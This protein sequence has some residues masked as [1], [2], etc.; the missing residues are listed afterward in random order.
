MSSQLSVTILVNHLRSLLEIE[1]AANGARVRAKR[2]AQAEF[3]A[4][5]IGPSA[6]P[7]IPR[8]ESLSS[9]T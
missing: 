6:S 1:T 9:A 8:S 3:M 4:G 7:T 5:L 2:A